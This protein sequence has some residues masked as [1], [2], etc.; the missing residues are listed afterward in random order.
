MNA[1]KYNKIYSI[2]GIC[3]YL[4][5]VLGTILFIPLII[6][7]IYSEP[8]QIK[9]AFLL[10]AVLTMVTGILFKFIIRNKDINLNLTTSMIAVSIAWIFSSIIGAIPL[11]MGLELNFIDAL[12]EAVSG[13]T[14]TGITVLQGLDTMPRSVIFWR[15]LMQWLGGLGI[16]TFFL[17]VSSRFGGNLWQLFSAEGHKIDTSRPVPNIFKTVKILWGIYILFTAVEIILLLLFKVSFYEAVIHSFSTIS[18]G[19]FS[20]Y[21]RSIGQ[22]AAAGHPYFR[23]IEYIIIFF[24]LLGGINFLIHFK[25]L[26]GNFRAP[27]NNTELKYFF[28]I[29]LIFI[30]LIIIGKAVTDSG[31]FWHNI[32]NGIE[33]KLRTILFQVVTLITSTGFIT[34]DINSGFF[35]AIAKQLFIILMLIGGCVGSTSGGI[36]VLRIVLLNSLFK[37]EIKKLYYPRHA[38]LPVTLDHNIIDTEEIYRVAALVTGWLFL[39]M[40]GAVITALFS[41][42]D[43]FQSFSGM[44]SAVGNMG[45]FYFSVEKMSSLSPVIKITYIIGMLAGR[46]EILPVFVLLS[47]KAWYS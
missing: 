14:T 38:V 1:S 23:Q 41:D 17:L 20:S 5:L 33:E 24:M 47:K 37:R 9:M 3:S 31:V 35:P 22:Y 13:F 10:P 39:I 19:G 44:I 16:L 45:P 25:V 21:D 8:Y 6:S 2:T 12:F 32:L 18:T 34:R 42:L 26:T 28:R 4:L 43:A 15:S 46:L 7:F 30:L 36:K 29:I 27:F 40:I 11:I